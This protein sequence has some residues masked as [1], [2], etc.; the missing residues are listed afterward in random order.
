MKFAIVKAL[1]PK[2]KRRTRALLYILMAMHMHGAGAMV[3]TT[4]KNLKVKYGRCSYGTVVLL[5]PLLQRNKIFN[6]H[7]HNHYYINGF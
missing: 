1:H 2:D 3:I 7:D 6:I 5:V 4:R